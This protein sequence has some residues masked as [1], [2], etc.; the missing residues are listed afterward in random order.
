MYFLDFATPK[1]KMQPNERFRF[2]SHLIICLR[3]VNQQ[4]ATIR[5]VIYLNYLVSHNFFKSI[6]LN[7]F[8]LIIN[9]LLLSFLDCLH[10]S[11]KMGGCNQSGELV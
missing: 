2:F 6:N 1:Y 5:L 9:E 8:T 11:V 4:G 7:N 10:E 3:I